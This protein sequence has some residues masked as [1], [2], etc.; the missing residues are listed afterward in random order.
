MSEYYDIHNNVY[1]IIQRT[2]IAENDEE[3][4]EN[5]LNELYNIFSNSP[6]LSKA[7]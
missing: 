1:K 6:A 2:L 4:K 3:A 5:I 7:V